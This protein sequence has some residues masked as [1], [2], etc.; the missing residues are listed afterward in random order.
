MLLLTRR[1]AGPRLRERQPG[2]EYWQKIATQMA[3]GPDGEI[4]YREFNVVV[5]VGGIDLLEGFLQSAHIRSNC[6]SFTYSDISKACYA[7]SKRKAAQGIQ[8]MAR[9]EALKGEICPLDE[10]IEKATEIMNAVA[11]KH[12]MLSDADTSGFRQLL[13]PSLPDFARVHGVAESSLVPVWT[14][15]QEYCG[16]ESKAVA[17]S[18]SSSQS[19]AG[20]VLLN[21]D[22]FSPA[23]PGMVF[24]V[25]QLVGGSHSWAIEAKQDFVVQHNGLLG[26]WVA[27]AGSEGGTTRLHK[28]PPAD[29]QAFPVKLQD[30]QSVALLESGVVRLLSLKQLLLNT[31]KEHEDL[32]IEECLRALGYKV[33]VNVPKTTRK[34][35]RNAD[36]AEDTS[37]ISLELSHQR[38]LV[39]SHTVGQAMMNSHSSK[40]LNHVHI[41]PLLEFKGASESG[42][43]EEARHQD[44][45]LCVDLDQ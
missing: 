21:L 10:H 16:A 35:Q 14:Y 3:M 28:K 24:K 12:C 7:L 22:S 8:A 40:L 33:R 6:K 20:S 18:S 45:V 4:I 25:E 1:Q 19:A 15:L 29:A 17:N 30:K 34:R 23:D 27:E 32:K 42:K 5:P 39:S 38:Y 41:L 31:Q 43:K 9:D 13:I 11:L 2:W 44:N 37:N 36:T 26:H